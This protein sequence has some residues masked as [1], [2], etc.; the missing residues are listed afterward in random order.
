MIKT[1]MSDQKISCLNSV[2][3]IRLNGYKR[4]QIPYINT[5]LRYNKNHGRLIR[6]A[7]DLTCSISISKSEDTGYHHL[8]RESELI[9]KYSKNL[10]YTQDTGINITTKGGLIVL[11]IFDGHGGNAYSFYTEKVASRV[12]R[13]KLDNEWKKIYLRYKGSPNEFV[14]IERNKGKLLRELAVE[15]NKLTDEMIEELCVCTTSGT[16]V[17]FVIIDRLS[18]SMYSYN[19]GDSKYMI[20]EPSVNYNSLFHDFNQ[21]II[22]SVYNDT[23]SNFKKEEIKR[24]NGM[25]VI[26]TRDHSAD[27]ELEKE[28]AKKL[29]IPIYQDSRGTWRLNG[30]LMVTGGY[31]DKSYRGLRRAYSSNPG[32]NDEGEIYRRDIMRGGAGVLTSDGIFESLTEGSSMLKF[33][34]HRID[35]IEKYISENRKIPNLALGLIESQLAEIESIGGYYCLTGLKFGKGPSPWINEWDNHLLYVVKF[36]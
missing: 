6:E 2:K 5:K 13:K 25:N 31:G 24:D 34:Q 3:R 15:I 28:R 32:H 11:G 33:R 12:F 19:L 7:G 30:Q 26:G 27:D 21:T 4:P 14:E 22:N 20:L 17:N 8:G 36:N 29:K 18:R 1:L 16:T 10:S 23:Y 35:A 9:G